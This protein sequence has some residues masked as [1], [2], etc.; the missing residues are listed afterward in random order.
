MT[1][2]FFQGGRHFSKRGFAPLRPP[3]YGSGRWTRGNILVH[4]IW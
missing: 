3:G 2:K 4:S 1:N